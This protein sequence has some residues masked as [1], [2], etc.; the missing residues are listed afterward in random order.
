[1]FR[2]ARRLLAVAQITFF[3][4]AHPLASVSQ[5]GLL[6]LG[7]VLPWREKLLSRPKL[8]VVDPKW[9]GEDDDIISSE[10]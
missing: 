4:G 10:S 3:D 2:S 1:M 7:W 8:L 9:A 5:A 6:I